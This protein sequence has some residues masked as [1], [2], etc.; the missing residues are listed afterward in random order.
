MEVSD[1]EMTSFV[2]VI[3][4]GGLGLG[5]GGGV[6]VH[7]RCERRPCVCQINCYIS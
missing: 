6:L 2:G 3:V 1:A 7:V 4:K 5:V